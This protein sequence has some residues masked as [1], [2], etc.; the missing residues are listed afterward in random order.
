MR[1]L[2]PFRLV[3]LAA[4]VALASSAAHAVPIH[5]HVEGSITY[6]NDPDGRLAALG[7]DQDS[8]VVVDLEYDAALADSYGSGGTNYAEVAY[9]LFPSSAFS[10]TVSAGPVDF[11]S[12]W[13]YAGADGTV[14]TG[15]PLAPP[16]PRDE[17][18][19]GSVLGIGPGC[20]PACVD[21]QLLIFDETNPFDLL[22]GKSVLQIPDISAV[23]RAGGQIFGSYV[24]GDLIDF[25]FQAD[26][27][28]L[29]VIPEPGTGLLAATGLT[30]LFALGLR[31]GRLRGPRRRHREA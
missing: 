28:T 21:L 17:Y 14:S 18:F 30:A 27:L 5:L 15:E 31:G 7:I 29:E 22:D 26:S 6:L 2:L 20:S 4:F 1:S 3:L 25:S 19:F 24:G 13:S 23:S 11:E 16:G 9:F 8:P 12:A 10:A